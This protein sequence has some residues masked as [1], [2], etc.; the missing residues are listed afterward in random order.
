MYGFLLVWCS[1]FVLWRAVFQVFDFKKCRD[2]QI[3]VRGHLR[4]LN[5]VPFDSL[6]YCS[7]V[8]L[9]VDIGLQKYRDLENQVR[10][11]S[12]S[13][14]MSPFDRESMTSYWSSIVTMA[15][16]RV[17]SEVF[18]VEKHCDLEILVKGHSRILKV[19]PFD[20]LGMVSY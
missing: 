15:L 10:G 9:S 2:L 7:I 5:E 14:K 18:N 1:N 12:K 3:R 13:L 4:S 17:V 20:R 8:T 19:V 11:P 6:Y 16:S